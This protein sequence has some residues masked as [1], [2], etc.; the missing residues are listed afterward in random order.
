M[1]ALVSRAVLGPLR[2]TPSNWSANLSSLLSPTVGHS[3]YSRGICTRSSNTSRCSSCS[4]TGATDGRRTR[5]RLAAREI[6]EVFRDPRLRLHRIDVA[7]DR[8]ERVVRRVIEPEEVLH[9]VFRRGRE[10]F[11]AADDVPRIRI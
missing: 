2:I 7:D 3:T 1:S 6:A 11:H 8:E 9:V 5:D 10:I 4:V